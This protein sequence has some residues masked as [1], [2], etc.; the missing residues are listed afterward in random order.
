MPAALGARWAIARQSV[1]HHRQTGPLREVLA[2]AVRWA[3]GGMLIG[4]AAVTL[5]RAMG[6]S[7][8]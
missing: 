2:E 3:A 4:F 7:P 5:L 8:V 1:E 6:V